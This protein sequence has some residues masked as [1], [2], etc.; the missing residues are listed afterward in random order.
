MGSPS[1]SA[2]SCRENVHKCSCRTKPSPEPE[3][4]CPPTAYLRCCANVEKRLLN[5]S[6]D[7]VLF[8]ASVILAR[9]RER[10]AA[11]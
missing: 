9:E 7:S 2:I 4:P 5:G 3:D 11:Q 10:A 6:E 1:A 8:Y